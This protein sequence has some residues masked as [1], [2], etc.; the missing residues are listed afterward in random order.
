MQPAPARDARDEL[1]HKHCA[2]PGE[3]TLAEVAGRVA[4]TLAE[5]EP[6]GSRAGWR[7]RCFEL[8]ESTR[9]LPSVPILSNAGRSGQLAAC[10]VLEASDSL[11]SIYTTLARAARIQQGSG[12]TGV[13][14]SALRPRGTPIVR[15][16]GETPGPVGFLELFAASARVNRKAGRRPGAHLAILRADHPDVLAFVRAKRETPR[17]LAGIE[18]AIAASDELFRAA[19]AGA[20]IELVDPEGARHGTLSAGLL[21]DEICRSI[22]ATGEPCL[23]FSD[24]LERANPVPELGPLR[25]T[26]PCGEQPLLPGE[27]CVLASLH[28]PAFADPGGQLDLAALGRAA[29]DG[30]RM[31][32]DVIDAGVF[33]DPEIAQTSRR[34]RKIGLGVMG[35]ADVLLL[36]GLPY[37]C[38]EAR[39]LASAILRCVAQHARAAS[40]R[41]AVER[42]PFPAQRSGS[43]PRRNAALLA[44]APTGVLSLL[45]GCSAGIE[46]FIAPQVRL[47]G[48]AEW[49]DRWLAGWLEARGA[50]A[51]ELWDALARETPTPELSGLAPADRALLRRAWEIDPA[52]QIRVQ[53][54]LQEHVDGAVS[55]TVHLPEPTSPGQIRELVRLAHRLGCKGAAFFRRG[56]EPLVGPA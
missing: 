2:A 41:L 22:H 54:A 53:A 18:L 5:V 33:P 52:A 45:A 20:A 14:L 8:I 10:F 6:A 17:A 9:L 36:R 34:T 51:P 4:R 28:L 48:G 23:L 26:N 21:L 40:E 49:R 42:G 7:E 11:D 44:I 29:E 30:V 27:S 25:A 37:D 50:A 15:S 46:P 31:L 19:S 3:H 32:D 35:L 55:K 24:T 16:G 1:V 39:H 13:E 12:G 38:P 56:C 43:T 47:E